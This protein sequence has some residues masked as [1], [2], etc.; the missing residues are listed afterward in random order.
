MAQK[1]LDPGGS[2]AALNEGHG[3]LFSSLAAARTLFA[4]ELER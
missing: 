2:A 4:C 3:G 1:E